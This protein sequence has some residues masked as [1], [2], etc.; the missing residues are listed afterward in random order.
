MHQQDQEA[1]RLD[2]IR[3]EILARKKAH[4]QRIED[5]E[6]AR[7]QAL[8]DDVP[9]QARKQ[10]VEGLIEEAQRAKKQALTLTD[11][12]FEAMIE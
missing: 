5:A 3:E 7:R 12:E 8:A 2:K 6:D 10:S 11:A 1:D 9:V 4:R